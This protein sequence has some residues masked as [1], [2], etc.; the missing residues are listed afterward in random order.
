MTSLTLEST[1]PP[2]KGRASWPGALRSEWT[3]IRSLRSTV[4]TLIATAA[5]TIGLSALFAFGATQHFKVRGVPPHFDLVRG[6]MFGLIF[7]QLVIA[8]LGAMTLTGEYGTGM[9]RT[10][11]SAQPRRYVTILS[12]LGVFTAVALVTGLIC[13]FTSFFIGQQ[14]F[15]QVHQTAS[16]SDPNVLRA[17]IGGA[18]FL[19]V[20]GLLAFGLGAILRHTAGAITASVG[21]LFISFILFQFLPE[22][23]QIEV[24]RWIPFFDGSGIWSTG[25]TEPHLWGPWTGFAVFFGYAL[26][27]LIGGIAT[28]RTRDA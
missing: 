23:W 2:A 21:V 11:L 16:L 4:W 5:V 27:A 14:I 13:T 28:F 9:I 1:L 24:Q 19:T 7:G 10:S 12:K 22:D 6:S 8:V 20:A 25:P 18:L 26:I 15:G 3:K 17:V